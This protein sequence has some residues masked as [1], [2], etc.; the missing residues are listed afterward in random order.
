[1][2]T[3]SVPT[4]AQHLL[5]PCPAAIDAM[6]AGASARP[7]RPIANSANISGTTS[8]ARPRT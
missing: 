8:S 6:L 7:R 1:M 2:K 4:I 5:A 3:P